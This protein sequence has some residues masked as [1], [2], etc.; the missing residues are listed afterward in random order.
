VAACRVIG[1]VLIAVT[2]SSLLGCDSDCAEPPGLFEPVRGCTVELE[3]GEDLFAIC[4]DPP[5]GEP[6][7]GP[8]DPLAQSWLEM[9]QENGEAMGKPYP[10]PLRVGCGPITADEIPVGEHE[11]H[12]GQCCWLMVMLEHSPEGNCVNTVL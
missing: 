5:Q 9:L 7:G 4:S 8:D 12:E 2:S 3:A 11:F 6:C 10:Y 1:A